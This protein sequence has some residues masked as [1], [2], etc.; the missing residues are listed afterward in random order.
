MISSMYFLRLIE[1]YPV[2]ISSQKR[3]TK[4]KKVKIKISYYIL[5]ENLLS[6]LYIYKVGFVTSWLYL[7]C[8]KTTEDIQI[9]H[10]S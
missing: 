4:R 7:F 9:E 6:F 5:I 10:K 2:T 8:I 1:S 3:K